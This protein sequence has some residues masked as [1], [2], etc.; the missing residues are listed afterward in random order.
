MSYSAR[1]PEA[2]E[3]LFAAL[4]GDPFYDTLACVASADPAE[5]RAAMLC[6]LDYSLQEAERFGI[7]SFAPDMSHGAAAWSRPLEAPLAARVAREKKAFI[8]RHMGSNC[9][10]TYQAVTQNMSRKTT[11]YVPAGC[12]YLSIVGI[13]PDVQGSGIGRQLVED[14]LRQ[15]DAAGVRSYL[16]TFT[17]RNISFYERLGYVDTATVAEPVTGADY[18]VMV[19]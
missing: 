9:L 10:A 1:Y 18:T 17:P 16:E 11:K 7:V 14:V 3:A 15:A 13:S 4:A 6:Y 5:S 2:A 12:W 8:A 19:R